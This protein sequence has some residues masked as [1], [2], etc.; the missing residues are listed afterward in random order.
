MRTNRVLL[1]AA[2]SVV[3]LAL[4]GCG[5]DDAPKVPAAGGDPAASAGATGGGESG[6]GAGGK[7]VLATYV[8]GK[9][10]WV[11]CMREHGVE[12]NDPDDKGQIDFGDGDAARNMKKNPKFETATKACESVNPPMPEGL[13]ELVNPRPELTAE[14]IKAARDYAACMQKNGAP[15][16]PDPGPDGYPEN[17]NSGVSPWDQSSAGAQRATRLCAPISGNPTGRPPA[18]G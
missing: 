11:A 6:G 7:D 10:A 13:E 17:D 5:T 18:K 15:D 16:Y 4:T 2:V 9:R 8:E 3:A 1:A 14:Q 12:M